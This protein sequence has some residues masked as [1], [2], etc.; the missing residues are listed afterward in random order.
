VN[1]SGLLSPDNPGKNKAVQNSEK[2]YSL[3][4]SAGR[5]QWIWDISFGQIFHFRGVWI[6]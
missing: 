6:K 4:S 2:V 5:L 3:R 1:N